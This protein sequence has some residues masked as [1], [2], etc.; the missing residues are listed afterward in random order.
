[1]SERRKMLAWLELAAPWM[2]PSDAAALVDAVLA[3]PRRWKADTLAK[4]LG[5]TDAMRR[6]LNIRTIGASDMTKAERQAARRERKREA[7]RRRRRLRGQQPRTEY[8]ENSLTH[9]QPWKQVGLS[10][11]TWYR[12][13]ATLCA[14]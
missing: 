3:K 11:A 12:R 14:A 1:G 2:Q 9:T 4:R 8:L 10:R 7:Q 13:R 6:A 5:L